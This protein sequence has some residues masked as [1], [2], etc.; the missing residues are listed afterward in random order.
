MFS[1]WGNSD[2]LSF[3]ENALLRQ[4]VPPYLGGLPALH[5]EGRRQSKPT[6]ELYVTRSPARENVQHWR[7]S[8]NR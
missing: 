1:R 5:V 8:Y 7:K 3:G 6:G 4:G 2:M